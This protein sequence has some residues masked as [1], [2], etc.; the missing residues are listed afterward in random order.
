[1]NSC[2]CWC[3]VAVSP[4]GKFWVVWKQSPAPDF[5]LLFF[6][7]IDTYILSLN[8]LHDPAWQKPDRYQGTEIGAME[9]SRWSFFTMQV[10]FSNFSHQWSCCILHNVFPIHQTIRNRTT[11]ML[12]SAALCWDSRL[13][14]VTLKLADIWHEFLACWLFKNRWGQTSE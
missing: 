2:P 10:L 3:L 14:V 7:Y 6:P 11:W 13:S 9:N 5:S 12:C 8:Q 1:M 4:T